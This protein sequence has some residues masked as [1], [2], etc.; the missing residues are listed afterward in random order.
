[1]SSVLTSFL[2]WPLLLASLMV[3]YFWAHLPTLGGYVLLLAVTCLTTAA[4]ALFCSVLFQKTSV[5]MMASYLVILVL[6]TLP[7][8][9][10]YFAE[11]FYP[12]TSIAQWGQWGTFI[13]PFST[14]FA[15]P[16][17]ADGAT[18]D[19]RPAQW[20]V[21]FRFLG[22]YSLLDLGLLAGMMRLFQARW[23]VSD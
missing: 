23:R 15:L 13:S 21:W 19:P 2:L 20:D 6:F 16:L 11:R 9:W 10:N 3:S 5:S 1:V 8:A 12:Q 18:G 14:A 7:P 17:S 4:V 22:F